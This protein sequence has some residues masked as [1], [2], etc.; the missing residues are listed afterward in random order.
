[1][2][3]KGLAIWIDGNSSRNASVALPDTKSCADSPVLNQC[4]FVG[5]DM[6]GGIANIHPVVSA[7]QTTV[8]VDVMLGALSDT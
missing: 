7:G 6:G 3:Q 5:L 4:D 8:S 1:M 2:H